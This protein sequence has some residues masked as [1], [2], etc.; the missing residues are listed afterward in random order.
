MV[1]QEGAPLG[2]QCSHRLPALLER[3]TESGW[4]W[5]LGLGARGG[6]RVGGEGDGVLGRILGRSPGGHLDEMHHGRQGLAGVGLVW[7]LGAENRGRA[8]ERGDLSPCL[9]P[10]G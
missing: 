1:L 10:W 3:G 7:G 2:D 5:S 4:A 8:A 9:G 6:D